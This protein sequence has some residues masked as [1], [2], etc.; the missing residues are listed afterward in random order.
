MAEAG[1]THRR[2]L[3][4]ALPIVISNATVPLLGAVDTGV[5]G[6]L[7]LA[8]P[9]GAVG[10]GAVA[11]SSVYWIFGFLR[12]GTTGLT[13][14]ALGQ[15]HRDE[16]AALFS[17]AVLIG[18]AAGLALICLQAPLLWATLRI[19]PASAEVETLAR[20]YM[21]I[22][23][24][25]APAMIVLY[26]VTG[27]LIARE[28]TRAVLV[29]QVLMNGLNI[30]LD[31]VLVLGVGMGVEGVAL[32]TF[33]AEWSGLALGLWLCRDV[34]RI[35]AWCDLGRILDPARLRTMLGVNRDIM[36]RSVM[37]QAIFV[38]FMMLSSR[39]GDVTLAA[40]QVLLQFLYVTSYALDGFALAAETLVGQAFG[41]GNRRALRRAAGMTSLWGLVVTCGLAL[42]CA[43]GGGQVIH[44]LVTAPEVRAVAGI[45]L[46]YLVVAPVVGL[47]SFMLDGIFI[48]A[49]R[50]RDMRDMM[51]L[52]LAGYLLALAVLLPVLGNHGLWLALLFS[53]VLRG[54]TLALRYPALESRAGGAA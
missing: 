54:L 20:R 36:L 53:L 28:R 39:E 41:A 30:V 49:T 27:W 6:Q 7:G 33:I 13:S 29:I 34:L 32:A 16:V 25:S 23:I 9:I 40:N 35:P 15:G 1:L 4:I 44:I 45:Y 52:S 19:F 14:Q 21:Q 46:P 43:L 17:R 31:L 22:R 42:A 5:I 48:G 38:I 37:L 26:G 12:M 47:A 24:F 10:V 50:A 11:L 2:V 18:L 8:A 51:A 3:N